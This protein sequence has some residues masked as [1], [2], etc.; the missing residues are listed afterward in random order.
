MTDGQKKTNSVCI[1]SANAA[2]RIYFELNREA[3]A[4]VFSVSHIFN[5]L[6]GRHFKLVNDNQ[7]AKL[8]QWHQG[9]CFAIPLS[10]QHSTR[11]L[12]SKNAPIT[13]MLIIFQKEPFGDLGINNKV[14]C[15]CMASGKEIS[16][17]WINADVIR[18]ATDSDEQLS[19]T[20]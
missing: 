9:G 7:N 6:F 8:H 20:K 2:E 4:V 17:G 18:K 19:R 14:N 1:Q 13:L 3:L 15:V 16:A 11:K 10:S 12:S 5:Y